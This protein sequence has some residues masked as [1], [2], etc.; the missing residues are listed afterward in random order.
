MTKFFIEAS[1]NRHAD[2]RYYRSIPKNQRINFLME[3][4]T[5]FLEALAKLKSKPKPIIMHGSLIGFKFGQNPLPWDD[6]IDLCFIGKD[7]EEIKKLKN[8][9][10]K[11][12]LFEINPNSTN[13][14]HTDRDNVIDARI[15]H[16]AN[17]LFID[18]TFLTPVGKDYVTCKS[19]HPYKLDWILPLQQVEFGG[20]K[21]WVP[22]KIDEVL[23]SEYGKNV[24][25]PYFDVYSFNN[26]EGKWTRKNSKQEAKKTAALYNTPVSISKW[27]EL[28]RKSDAHLTLNDIISLK[29]G[30]SIDILILDKS[31]NEFTYTSGT[32]SSYTLFE[33]NRWLRFTKKS[34]EGIVG[35][36]EWLSGKPEN[37]DLCTSEFHIEFKKDMWYPLINGKVPRGKWTMGT[38]EDWDKYP[39]NTR[40]GWRGPSIDKNTMKLLPDIII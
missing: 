2:H 11:I 22:N 1:S 23:V 20:M 13:R 6:D 21:G 18:I 3:L 17:G 24:L 14:S 36:F 10:N 4:Y 30:E 8:T 32:Y 16:R 35:T 34:I 31:I 39:T 5:H 7:I 37:D 25:L 33:H 19:P 26:R 12:C 38:P 28:G 15:I 27:I 29:I 9:I 40:I